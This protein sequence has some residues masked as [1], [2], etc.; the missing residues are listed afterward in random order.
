MITK[1]FPID[2][3]PKTILYCGD[4][5]I[6]SSIRIVLEGQKNKYRSNYNQ[7]SSLELDE[8]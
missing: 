3:W 1:I 4:K 5:A 2:K 7:Y 6:E 8:I